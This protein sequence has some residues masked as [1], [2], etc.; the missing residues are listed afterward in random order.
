M[1]RVMLPKRMKTTSLDYLPCII[2]STRRCSKQ[3][4]FLL[5]PRL[6]SK[7]C[8]NFSNS[9]I[10]NNTVSF[11]SGHKAYLQ[12][13]SARKRRPEVLCIPRLPS[14]ASVIKH[15]IAIVIKQSQSRLLIRVFRPTVDLRP[16]GPKQAR[17]G[18]RNLCLLP[19]KGI[20]FNPPWF[21]PSLFK[22]IWLS[23]TLDV[24]V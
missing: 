7:L 9:R 19:V 17:N 1:N 14:I 3:S 24:F 2:Y 13:H 6:H 23:K 18:M 20:S 10:K 21:I 12:S 5:T 8:G 16:S 22:M 11:A 4:F 15:C